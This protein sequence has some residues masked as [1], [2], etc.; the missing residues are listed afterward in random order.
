MTRLPDRIRL[1]LAFDAARLAAELDRFGP[2][3]WVRHVA[4]NDYEGDWTVLPLRAAAGET[5]PI[6][7]IYPDLGA[8]R[9]VDTALL[10]RTTYLREVLGA[11]RCPLRCVRLMKLAAGSRIKAH[12]DPGLDAENEFVRLHVPISGDDGVA[13]FVNEERVP[14]TPGSLWYLRL[15]DPHRVEHGGEVDRVNLVIDARIDDWLARMLR[16]AAAAS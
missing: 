1:P 11:F 16:S 15:T 13:F 9:F 5:H 12:C 3:D 2:Q 8:A 4:R 10:G 7:M 6:R 14:M